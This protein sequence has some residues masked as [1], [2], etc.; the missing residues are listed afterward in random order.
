M[1]TEVLQ[2]RH[3]DSKLA[4]IGDNTLPGLP[5]ELIDE[6]AGRLDSASLHNLRNTTK[7]LA[8]AV[9]HNYARRHPTHTICHHAKQ[10]PGFLNQ[11]RMPAIYT[12]INCLEMTGG[13]SAMAYPA[14]PSTFWLPHL[15]KLVLMDIEM[16][17]MYLLNICIY[18]RP[19]LRSL[20]IHNVCIKNL[21]C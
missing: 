7:W 11:L 19:I 17:D 12:H 6:I 4:K 13:I 5:V 15:S 10:L 18:H 14:F 16:D 3:L 1:A 9:E 20:S 8:A 21:C 2:E